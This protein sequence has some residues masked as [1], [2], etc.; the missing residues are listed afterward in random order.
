MN[1]IA[2]AAAAG[3]CGAITT[4]A[5]HELTR[6][7]IPDA[8]RVDVLGM[9]ALAKMLDSAGAN[10]PKGRSLYNATLAADIVSN[11]AYFSGVA[12]GRNAVLTGFVLGLTAG[13]GAVL[14]PKPMG[15]AAEPTARTGVTAVLTTL[16]YTAGGLAA[17]LMYERLRD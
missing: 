1:S 16:L 11:G 6:R 15:L 10:V 17:G 5:L 8:P 4:N 14:L 12:A 9:Q 3:I 7:T 13:I 2:N